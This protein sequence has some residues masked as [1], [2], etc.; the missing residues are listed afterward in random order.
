MTKE[1]WI[2]YPAYLDHPHM[3]L[4]SRSFKDGAVEYIK[5]SILEELNPI[6]YF[7]RHPVCNITFSILNSFENPKIVV[8]RILEDD[9]LGSRY[10]EHRKFNIGEEMIYRIFQAFIPKKKPEKLIVPGWMYNAAFNT[11]KLDEKSLYEI[12]TKTGKI[13]KIS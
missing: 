8:C 4:K 5:A 9:E 1:T 11:E 3:E 7:P 12:N 10:I 2:A 6:Q 13:R